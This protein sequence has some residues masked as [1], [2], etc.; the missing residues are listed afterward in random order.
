M[1]TTR[2]VLRD[3]RPGAGLLALAVVGSIAIATLIIVPLRDVAPAISLGGLYLVAVL[4]VSAWGGLWPGLATALLG[5]AAYN[6]FLIEP[7]GEFTV[8]RGRDWYALGIFVVV[9]AVASSLAERARARLRVSELRRQEAAL[10]AAA[11]GALLGEGPLSARLT[12]TARRVADAAGAPTC[13]IVPDEREA[14]G[15][16]TA[17]PLEGPRGRVGTLLVPDTLEPGVVRRLR[18]RVAPSL[19]ALLG[20][21]IERDRL[22]AELVETEAL[23]RSDTLKTALLRAVSHD[24][25]SPLTAIVAAGHALGSPTLSQDEREELSGLVG[26]EAARLDGVIEKL[27]DLSRLEA[28]SAAPQAD[29]CE[30][31]ELLHE[32][33]EDVT[34][35]DPAGGSFTFAL[36]GELP[37]VRADPAQI[38]RVFVN[39]LEN[40]RRSSAGRPVA[41]RAKVVGGRV[42]VRVVDQGPGIP[43]ADQ[44]RV[45]EPFF[46]VATGDAAQSAHAGSGLGLAIA[47]GFVEANGG[48]ISVESVPGQGSSFVVELPVPQ[49]SA[50]AAGP[51]A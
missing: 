18:Q 19:G 7:T 13:A 40:A 16:Q 47:K 2:P 23:R 36:H 46:R 20:A 15:G 33:A 22:A 14:P 12:Q 49:A 50:V 28:G 1:T 48:R 3:E 11:A 10:T 25:R 29:W 41:V 44:R 32:A 9:A 43:T 27:L 6:W 42:V 34:R 35:R 39:L 17:I 38:E 24:L 51:R 5:A 21:A 4:G 45:F 31:G 30:I 8:A 26:T 37:L